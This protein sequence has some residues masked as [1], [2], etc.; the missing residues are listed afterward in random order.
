MT[1]NEV[2]FRQIHLDFHTSELIEG[3]GSGFDAKQFAKTL[4]DARVDS[5]N[6]FVRCHHGMIYYDSKKFPERVHPHLKSRDMLKQ[7]VEA[8]RARGIHV[9]LYVTVRWDVYS[10]NEH[11]EWVA[12]DAEG[13]YSDYEKRGYLEAGFY[14]NLCVNTGYR[15]FLKENLQEVMEEIP[16]EGVWFDASFV[17]E[18]VCPTCMKGMREAGL[19]PKNAADRKAYSEITYHD[20]VQDMSAQ[21]RAF[22][23]DYNIFYNKGHVGRVDKPVLDD[24]TYAAFESLPGGP[25][26]YM[27]FP[28]SVK[29]I[30]T[31]GKETVG[32]TGRFHTSWGDN[33]SFRNK[34]ALEFECY[35]MLAQGSKCNIGDQLE[36]SGV[37]SEAM[38]E[39]IGEVY[40]QVEKK[41]SWCREVVAVTDI[42]V[43]TPEEFYGA[44]TG[45]LPEAS[46]GVC[47]MLQESGHQFDFIDSA[48][49]FLK[50]KVL[51]LPDVIPV[52]EEFGRRLQHYLDNGGSIIASFE[53]GLNPEKTM[54]TLPAWGVRYKGNAPYSPDFIVPSGDIGSGLKQAE[55]VMYKQGAWV[56]AEGGERL[57]DAIESVFNRSFEQFSSHLHSPSSGK[58]GYPAIVKKG[59][60][61][62]F[63]HPVF[64]Q[65]HD[66]APLWVKTLVRN[67][68]N[69]LL[70]DP[71]LKHNGPSTLLATVNEQAAENRQ[72][73]HL[74]H[75]IPERRS[76]TMDIIEDVIPLHD[77]RI[78]VKV[79]RDVTGVLLVPDNKPLDYETKDGR[80]E[81][82]VPK[83]TGHQMVELSFRK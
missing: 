40:S 73:V 61:I 66:N 7:Q 82:L 45:H 42:G 33:S 54:F 22:N 3:I 10:Y 9:N 46:E 11:P 31:L 23:P 28:V 8:C 12:I 18:C 51:I 72:V 65:Y 58:V 56:E 52:S 1:V 30:R 34:A 35:N 60:V 64:G 71:L 55:H 4:D 20:W 15:Q 43:F 48:E 74:L 79:D 6:L 69:M 29:Y 37:L 16:A 19:N 36:P 24:Y 27:D 5:I 75:Y 80:I 76:K 77:T 68:L 67:A 2:R 25:W 81:F 49:N 59:R 32:M 38:Y 26:G 17:V 44:D 62:Y 14:R 39:L 53:S 63:I 13:R 83:I 70:P 57:A 50:Y 41:E 78:S 47:R 21:V